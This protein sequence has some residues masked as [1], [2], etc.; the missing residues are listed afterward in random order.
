MAKMPGGLRDEA[1]MPAVEPERRYIYGGAPAAGHAGYVIRPNR[2]TVRR[3]VST[4]NLI[5]LLFGIGGAIVLY[6]SNII[7]IN[8]LSLEVE[9]SREKLKRITDTNSALQSEVD[10]KSAADKII[11]LAADQLGMHPARRP[12]V[13]F[14]IDWDKAHEL[15]VQPRQER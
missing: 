1:A 7:A 8:Q 9:L 10:R 14:S 13:W 6:I 11:P 2:K 5:L 15:G 3:K 4:F 12:P